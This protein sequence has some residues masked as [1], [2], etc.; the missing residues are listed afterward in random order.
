VFAGSLVALVT[1][2]NEDGS[3]NWESYQKLIQWHIE[4]GTQGLVVLGTTGE[5]AAMTSK[6]R[7]QLIQ[8]AVSTVNGKIPVIIGTGTNC[9][10]T[11]IK[12]TKEAAELGADAVLVV[13]PYYNRPPQAGLYGHFK[14]VAESTDLPVILYNVP[15]RTACDLLPETAARLAKIDNIVAVK[16]ATGDASRADVYQKLNTGLILLSGDDGSCQEFIQKGG[17]GVISVAANIA[18]KQMAELCASSSSEVQAKLVPLFDSMGAQANPIPVKWAAAKMNLIP[19]G[20]RLPLVPL[21]SA[22]HGQV[23]RAMKSA[24][25]IS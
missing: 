23:L 8:Q 6:E 18:P 15:A 21:E 24:G 25:L 19:P 9:T 20:I 4:Q 3:I 10:E 1:P 13:T 5:S 17:A 22:Y 7:T 14:A 12:N 2:M 16:E 11:T